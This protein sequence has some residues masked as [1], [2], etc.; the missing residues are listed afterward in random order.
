MQPY[1]FITVSLR[2]ILKHG[3]LSNTLL[4][5][6]RRLLVPQSNMRIIAKNPKPTQRIRVHTTQ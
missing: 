3:V 4:R 6:P 5:L 1:S 2:D